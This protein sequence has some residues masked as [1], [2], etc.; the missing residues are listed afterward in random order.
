MRSKNG[1]IKRQMGERSGMV[2]LS[3]LPENL[4][5][6]SPRFHAPRAAYS[7]PMTRRPRTNYDSPRAVSCFT[8]RDRAKANGADSLVAKDLRR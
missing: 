7:S 4:S 8:I 5:Q 3:A 6:T 2:L 1:R